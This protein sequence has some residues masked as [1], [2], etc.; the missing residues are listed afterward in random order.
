[1]SI[2]AR[3]VLY[4]GCLATSTFTE[5]VDAAATT[6]FDAVSIWPHLYR[7]AVERDGVGPAALRRILGDAGIAVSAI[8]AYGGWLPAEPGGTFRLGWTG[9]QFLDATAELGA[10]TVVAAHLGTAPLSVE[11][12]AERLAV[13]CDAA[14]AR[15][16]RVALEP[17]A[18]SAIAD[19]DTA[20]RIVELVARDNAG[21]V[22]DVGHLVRGGWSERGLRAVPADKVF[23]VQLVD[24][25]ALA[26]AD[27]VHEARFERQLP[28]QGE[29]P[30]TRILELLARH[31]VRTDVGPEVFHPPRPGESPVEPARRLA[32]AV[33]PF[34]PD[35]FVPLS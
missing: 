12:A 23:A 34:L 13:F 1:M 22:L 3:T 9:T 20:R 6:G 2:A 16:L 32:A 11:L 15:R 33:Q 5:L 8:E 26:P 31:G 35:R 21:L 24:G 28:G 27:L 30:I 4:A 7:R 14:A 10:D 25:P 17:L 18:F 19:L 29:F